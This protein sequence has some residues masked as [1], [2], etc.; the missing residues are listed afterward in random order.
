MS[1]K[2]GRRGSPPISPGPQ[3]TKK[4]AILRAMRNH[5]RLAVGLLAAVALSAVYSVSFF[6]PTLI[7]REDSVLRVPVLSHIR[8]LPRIMSRDFLLF[9]SGQFRP[10]SYV[11]LAFVRTFVASENVLFWHIWLLAFHFVNTLLIF[12]IARHFARRAAVALTAAALFALHPLSTVIVDDI[13]QFHLLLGL[14]LSLGSLKAYLSFSRNRSSTFYLA[15]VGLFM[16]AVLTARPALF[17]GL[18]VLVYELLYERS[19]LRWTLLRLLPFV[20][21]PVSLFPLW[22]WCTPHPLYYKYVAM[23]KGSFWHG[24]FS[25]TG[26]TGQYASGLLLTRGIPS[27]LH[28]LVEKIYR[29][30]NAKFL[31]WAAVNLVLVSGA[32]VVLI[33]KN[34]GGLGVLLI[35]IFM[36]PYASV[37][38]NRVVDYVSWSY[39]YFPAA[40]LA[41]AFSGAHELLLKTQRRNVQVVSHV[42]LLALSLFLAGRSVQLNVHARS[43]LAY[44][45]HVSDMNETSQTALY[46]TGK[47]YLEAGNLP[48]ASH[49]FF[50]PMVKDLKYPCLAMAR[51]Y[52]RQGNLLASAIHLRFGSIEQKTGIILEDHCEVAGELL[53]AAGALDHAEENFG[54][55][56]MVNPFNTQAMLGLARVWFVKG[57]VGEAY[58]MLERARAIA[59]KDREILRLEEEFRAA[60]RRWGESPE[61]FTIVPPKP[62]WL[63][64]VLT[65][66][67]TPSLRR[68]IVALSDAADPND[69]VIQLE[70]MVSLLEDREYQAAAEKAPKVLYGLSG[71]A[72]A[73]AAASRAFAHA[74][75]IDRAIQLGQR[76]ASLDSTSTLAWT[77]L[78][79]AYALQDK[80]DD[81]TRKFMK[82]M[83]QH[84]ASASVFYYNLAMQ[85]KR[86]GK[87]DEAVKL[88]ENALEAQPGNVEA[89]QSLGEV[90]LSLG[91]FERAR[92]LLQ[93]AVAANPGNAETHANLG[94]ALMNLRRDAEGVEALKTAVELNP[95]SAAY[96]S[97]LGVG[98]S[99]LKRDAESMR[100]LRRAIELDSRL[101]NARFNLANLL[102]G[103]GNLT[104]AVAEYREVIKIA[105]SHRYVHFNLAVILHRQDK[106]DEA[107]GEYQEEIRHN[108]SFSPAYTALI[109]VYCERGEHNLALDL[110]RRAADLG[111]K[112][113]A[114]TQAALRRISPDSKDD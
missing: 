93:K 65:Q 31:L 67:R 28:D 50:A 35:F 4:A 68:E 104:D 6:S 96:H 3:P 108:P 37:A 85:K 10:L 17:L 53:T 76:A 71:N 15:S 42:A 29:W 19:R 77:S 61:P 56:L 80:P 9:S 114:E 41:L 83:A 21:V 25:V 97:D 16:L 26:A 34:W 87:N 48:F 24:L 95:T 36:I 52:C 94:V 49:Y 66:V 111:V 7:L 59:P 107:I 55:V 38:Y 109:N 30:A 70:A 18:V 91:Q 13:N 32:V 112:L 81:A 78:A 64:Y 113:D 43:P 62:D 8:N 89:L 60:E 1:R 110:A 2:K 20:V 54:K 100:E 12:S 79:L 44:W 72:Y 23:Y 40:G 47:A 101:V 11:L 69:A 106:I 74:G 57:V 63:R 73:C 92:E 5:P 102:A 39:L 103:A 86:V 99:R 33:R 90:L 105:P 51:Y 98:L 84:P 75:D 88:F 58:R 27:V 14:T 82:A 45:K 22:A 46:E